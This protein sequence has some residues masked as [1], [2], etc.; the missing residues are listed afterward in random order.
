MKGDVKNIYRSMLDNL[1]ALR[2]F[3]AVVEAG[4]F[5]EAGY[6]LNVMP[7]TIS[8]HVSFL[9]EKI[10]GQLIVRSTKHLSV[11]ELGRRFYDRCLIILKEVEETEAEMLEYQME[12]QGKLRITMG[13]SFAGYHLPRLIPS[14]LER[15]PKISL[16]FRV[17]PELVDLIDHSIDVAV[18]ISSNLEP[19]LIAVKLAPNIRSVCVSPAYVEKFGMPAEPRDLESHNCLLTNEAS[20]TAK[21]RLLQDGVENVV[22]VSGNLVVNHGDIYKQAILDGV[23]IGHLSRYLVYQE[24]NDGRLIELF[25]DRGVINSFIYVVYPQRRNLPL[26][27]R[28]FIDHLRDAFRGTPE[29]MA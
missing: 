9:E 6:R 19:G 11:S 4:S 14:F 25:P 3:V 13:P 24:I 8:K 20:S 21:W 5:S 28:V 10:H 2:A 1:S 7:S 17:T 22:H 12:P 26:K 29:W 15:Y 18:R 23:G 27:T 16:D